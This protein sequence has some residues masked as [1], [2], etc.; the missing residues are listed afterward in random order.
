MLEEDYQRFSTHHS[1]KVTEDHCYTYCSLLPPR[2]SLLFI[3]H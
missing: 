1:R 2:L 3:D